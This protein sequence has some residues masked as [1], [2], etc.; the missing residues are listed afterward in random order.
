MFALL[1][2]LAACTSSGVIYGGEDGLSAYY[3][4]PA[5]CEQT[6]APGAVAG[7]ERWPYVQGITEDAA[8]VAWG[9]PADAAAGELVATRGELSQSLDAGG[10]PIS[11]GEGQEIRLFHARLTG[12]E[13]GTEYCY[14]VQVDG[15]TLA[16]G[17]RFRTAPDSERAPVRF[18]VIGDFGAG[19]DEQLM[20]RDQMLAH[21][22]GVDL[23]LTTGDNAY[24]DGD[25]HELHQHVFGVYQELLTRVPVF[26]VP[27]NHDYNTDAAAPY[28]A[29][30]FLPEQAR[31][32]GD[33]ERYYAIDW[34]PM[35]FVALDDNDPMLE[36]RSDNDDDEIDWLEDDLAAASRPWTVASFHQPVYSEHESRTPS[37]LNLAWYVPLFEEHGVQLALQGHNHF[38]ERYP[39]VKGGEVSS[40]AE[41][42]TVYVTTGGGGRSLYALKDP[43]LREVGV[44]EHHFLLGE[45]DDCELS[46]QA[47]SKTGELLDSFSLSRCD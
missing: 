2:S 28:L 35:H 17:L 36:I 18:M 25:W 42:G 32:D 10:E 47:I 20:V 3:A 41:G 7:L 40:L 15:V 23:L 1:L 37:L 24:S 26:P 21:S 13:P 12:L 27:G 29:N 4:E 45:I 14:A 34:G 11:I 46:I 39:A 33:Q 5:S 22:E 19:T 16:D 8:T 44:E 43:E 9:G 6:V 31:K 30:F 38:Y